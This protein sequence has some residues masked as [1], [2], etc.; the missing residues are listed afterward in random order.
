MTLPLP[1]PTAKQPSSEPK[2]TILKDYD[3]AN[4]TINGSPNLL[5]RCQ[6]LQACTAFFWFLLVTYCA[7]LGVNI[8]IIE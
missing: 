7:A 1:L 4:G 6:E 8:S 2:L 3:G 5:K